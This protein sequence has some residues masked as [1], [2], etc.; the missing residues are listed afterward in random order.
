MRRRQA[1][2]RVGAAGSGEHGPAAAFAAGCFVLG[3]GVGGG[4][5]RG[6]V[7]GLRDLQTI[8]GRG[9]KKK[10]MR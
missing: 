9:V 2:H 4:G 7:G 5:E 3:D 6:H 8:H 10:N 1:L